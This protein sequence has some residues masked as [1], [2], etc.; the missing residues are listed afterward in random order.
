MAKANTKSKT[1]VTTESSQEALDIMANEE[2][3]TNFSTLLKTRYPLYYITT[4][5]EKRLL[6]FLDHFC[7]TKGY[8]CRVWDCFR[9]LIDLDSGDV[10]GGADESLKEPIPILEH[11]LNEGKNYINNKEAVAKKRDDGVRGFIYVLLDYHRFID[12]NPDVERRLKAISNLEGI[13]STIITGPTYETTN[14]LENLIPVLDFPFPNKEEIKA[15]LWELV[16]SI[17]DKVPGIVAKTKKSEEM[18]I[19][20][21]SGLTLVEA[22]TAFAKSIVCN[23]GWDIKTILE[24]KKQIISKSGMLDFYNNDV[25]L[26][27]VG[28]LKNLVRWINKRKSSFSDEAKEYGIKPP[29][30]LL[31][32]GMP[33]C[34]KSLACKA[35][36][37]AWEMPLLRLDFG[38]LFDSLV[39]QSEARARSAIKLAETV[40][41]CILWIDEIEKGLSGVQSSGRS[42]G[43]TTSR[44]LS[45]FLTWMQEKTSPVFVVATANDHESI[46]PEFLRAGRFDEIFFV[47]L[48]NEQ[49]RKEIFEVLLKKRGYEAKD[50]NLDLLSGDPISRNYSGAEIEKAIDVAMLAGFD[51]KKRKIKDDDISKAI[52]GFKSLFEMRAESFETLQEWAKEKCIRANSDD[53]G[54][55]D[56]GIGKSKKTI[57]LE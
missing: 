6:T 7:R 34:G 20:S 19:N 8:K 46:P 3:K 18:L 36:S 31:T 47:D 38:K 49:E 13:V 22:Q 21:V 56:L 45:T 9:G 25:S 42:D 11:I 48:P 27:D 30:G 26:N 16:N 14:T 23:K 54:K 53:K 52:K 41:P 39:G 55:V 4:N 37:N 50:F 32:I 44:V 29:R 2:F 5:E 24:E 15:A 40:S 51:D 43:G 57:D 17:S 10:S 33:G 28:G 12:E 35:I 1:E